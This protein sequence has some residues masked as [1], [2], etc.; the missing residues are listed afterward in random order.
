MTPN[1]IEAA[2]IVLV[3]RLYNLSSSESRRTVR[4]GYQ[5][6]RSVTALSLWTT[7]GQY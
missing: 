5:V 4:E 1:I 6:I 2:Q 3:V 7:S